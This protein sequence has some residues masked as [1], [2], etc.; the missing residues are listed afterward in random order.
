[1]NGKVNTEKNMFSKVF[2]IIALIISI[3]ISI[4]FF[5][6]PNTDFQF[7][8]IP[9]FILLLLLTISYI[10]QTIECSLQGNKK[11]FYIY[12]FMSLFFIIIYISVFSIVL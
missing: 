9:P 11:H 3:G 4:Y 12:L 5:S 8:N 6:N 7:Y 1:M 10:I 2:D